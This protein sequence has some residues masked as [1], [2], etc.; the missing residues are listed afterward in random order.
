MAIRQ[1]DGHAHHPK[2]GF[3]C[4]PSVARSPRQFLPHAPPPPP[5]RPLPPP[6]QLDPV[7]MGKAAQWSLFANSTLCEAFF[8]AA[9]N[10]RDALLDV[11]REG[12]CARLG[13]G[14]LAM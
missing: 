5:P 7:A 13:E 1:V 14:G 6:G 11:R 12:P 8:G 4:T 9:R 10:K 3:R 2:P